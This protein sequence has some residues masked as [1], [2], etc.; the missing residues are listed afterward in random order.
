MFRSNG[1]TSYQ[2]C[3]H[4]NV[5]SRVKASTCNVALL[6]PFGSARVPVSLLPSV[7][8]CCQVAAWLPLSCKEPLA[9]LTWAAT[10]S[11]KTLYNTFLDIR[12]RHL[13]AQPGEVA[14]V[15]FKLCSAARCPQAQWLQ[16]RS[17]SPG[18]RLL[19]ALNK[20]DSYR[21]NSW[22]KSCPSTLI[23]TPEACAVQTARGGCPLWIQW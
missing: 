8:C 2:I 17:K 22:Y 20:L 11:S 5:P 14:L 16:P 12:C 13:G 6:L 10:A 18:G 9:V 7:A 21:D 23:A 1:L 4:C 19:T 15:Q 3:N